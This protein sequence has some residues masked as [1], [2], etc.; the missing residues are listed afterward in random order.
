MAAAAKMG[1]PHGML[2]IIGLDDAK[3]EQLCTQARQKL[4]AGSVCQM[5]NYLFPQ[6]RVVSGH[7]DALEEVCASAAMSFRIQ[8]FVHADTPCAACPAC[9]LQWPFAVLPSANAHTSFAAGAAAG[10]SSRGHQGGHAGRQRGLPHLAHAACQRCSCAGMP[11]NRLHG[12][13]AVSRP[14][15]PV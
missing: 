6:G 2:S 15:M 14:C 12:L 11:H 5:A 3:V 7:K 8:A 9:A 13:Q 10:S 4:G 1:K